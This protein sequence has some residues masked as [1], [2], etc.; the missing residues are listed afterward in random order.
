MEEFQLYNRA[1]NLA[2]LHTALI[3]DSLKEQLEESI[4]AGFESSLT[5]L[6]IGRD[7]LCHHLAGL[8]KTLHPGRARVPVLQRS[9]LLLHED[10]KNATLSFNTR[11]IFKL[12]LALNSA[13]FV[14]RGRV[15]SRHS[16]L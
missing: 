2:E 9:K 1:S 14:S 16:L 10:G 8:L 11:F 5:Q 12:R 4:P 13:W 15:S 6:S 3:E 7:E